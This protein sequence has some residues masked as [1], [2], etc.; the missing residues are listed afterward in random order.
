MKSFRGREGK[1]RAYPSESRVQYP[2]LHRRD[3]CLRI[4][5]SI[6]AA[7]CSLVPGSL[8]VWCQ[9]LVINELLNKNCAVEMK[10]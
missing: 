9:A 7:V 10:R 6:L 8:A 3:R 5:A 1:G 2:P 4:P